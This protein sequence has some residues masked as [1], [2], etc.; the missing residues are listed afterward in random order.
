MYDPQKFGHLRTARVWAVSAIH[1]DLDRLSVLH[2]ALAGRLH[3]RDG[4]VYTGNYLGHG[5]K[6]RSTVDELLAFRRWFMARPHAFVADI[7]HLRGQQ[8]EMWSKLLQLQ[9]A[10]NPREV[11]IWLLER[12]VRETLDAYGGSVD[13]GQIAARDGAVAITKWTAGLRAAIAASPGHTE[14]MSAL[15][16]AAIN[17]DSSV[18]FVHAGIDPARTLDE[19]RDSFWWG[20][21]GF[22]RLDRPYQCFQRVVRGFDPAHCGFIETAQTISIDAGPDAPGKIVAVCFAGSEIVD[23]VES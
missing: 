7:V 17:R 19:Q 16:R 11:L 1:G 15:R 20:T 3:V 5:V 22:E 23:A 9:F 12:G 10:P 13:L 14:F 8:E 18:L 21:A 6:T 2:D 4:L